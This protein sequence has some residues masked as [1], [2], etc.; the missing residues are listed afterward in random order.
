MS[1]W[2]RRSASATGVLVLLLFASAVPAP[3]ARPDA[4][5]P[6]G[7][8]AAGVSAPSGVPPDLGSGVTRGDTLAQAEPPWPFAVSY[9]SRVPIYDETSRTAVSSGVL[10]ADG[11]D[12]ASVWP[13][14]G[15]ALTVTGQGQGVG[16]NYRM[17]WWADSA[18]GYVDS[19]VCSTWT[20]AEGGSVQP[21]LALR[22]RTEAAGTRAIT[23]TN[24]IYF[25]ARWTW[26]T[27]LWE[28][29]ATR[30]N[31]IGRAVLPVFGSATKVAGG[32]DYALA[33]RPWRM[34]A[35]AVDAVLQFKVWP[36]SSTPVEPAWGDARY[37]A[38][39]VLPPEWVYPGRTGWYAGHVG[40]GET[41]TFDD[42]RVWAV[43]GGAG[44]VRADQARDA[45]RLSVVTARDIEK[46]LPCPDRIKK[47]HR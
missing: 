35:R 3:A 29:G 26:N 28:P 44:E 4:A 47:G 42:L 11:E 36:L 9:Q 16:S 7:E 20:A 45:C 17:V 12:A 13:G 30:L 6:A 23:I 43:R 34:C 10:V 5:R 24:N 15:G 31:Q 37:G 27:H 2:L 1:H 40:P 46:V 39:Y 21:G 33:P 18:P 25:A 14:A 32:I 19:Q 22:V 8:T 38:S 41:M